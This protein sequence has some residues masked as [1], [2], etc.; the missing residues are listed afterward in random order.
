MAS[1]RFAFISA[2]S[3]TFSSLHIRFGCSAGSVAKQLPVEA[4]AGNV[5]RPVQHARGVLHHPGLPEQA[6]RPR[7]ELVQLLFALPARALRLAPRRHV[8]CDPAQFPLSGADRGDRDP[9]VHPEGLAVLD[10]AELLL[11]TRGPAMQRR[12]AP[13]LRLRPLRP[14]QTEVEVVRGVAVDPFALD[15]ALGSENPVLEPRGRGAE[16]P[17]DPA[18]HLRHPGLPQHAIGPAEDLLQLRLAPLPRLLGLLEGRNVEDHPEQL[19]D[20]RSLGGDG[21]P[22]MQPVSAIGFHDV[23]FLLVARGA[24]AERRVAARAHFG[25]LRHRQLV[26]QFDLPRPG[27]VAEKL[28][29]QTGGG[30]FKNPFLPALVVGHA[31]QSKCRCRVWGLV[32]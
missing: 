20:S 30:Q 4:G 32:S 23:E 17:E 9:F 15:G 1:V 10:Q 16:P 26:V 18:V 5:E 14:F 29:L 27:L 12:G 22:L 8:D 13:R 31:A 21:N 11:V 24:V 3:G 2:S 28:L 6:V 7:Q 25:Q 19:P